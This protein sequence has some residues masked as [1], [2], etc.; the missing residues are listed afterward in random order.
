MID[1]IL[2]VDDNDADNFM[3]EMVIEDSQVT[4]Q[5]EIARNGHE[6]FDYL[7]G[8]KDGNSFPDLI[9]LDINMP[10]I[11]GWEFLDKVQA[12]K[13]ELPKDLKV[14]MLTTSLNPTDKKEAT[15]Y[16]EVKLFRNKPLNKALLKEVI[17]KLFD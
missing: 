11:N 16:E 6:A 5:I 2:L 17:E 14:V 4:K 1:C 10:I 9:F 13:A 12:I 15:K 7:N 8:V 3:H